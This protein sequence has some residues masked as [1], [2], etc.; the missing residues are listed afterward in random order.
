MTTVFVCVCVPWAII[1]PWLSCTVRGPG[2]HHFCRN[3][4][5]W[6][7]LMDVVVGVDVW[8]DGGREG[9]RSGQSHS[10]CRVATTYIEYPGN[11]PV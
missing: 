10:D 5:Q 1:S 7:G 9:G 3:V 11:I 4:C 6:A 2:Q 8:M